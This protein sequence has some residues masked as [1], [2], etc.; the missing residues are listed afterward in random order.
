MAE[1]SLR[2]RIDGSSAGL[3]AASGQARNSLASLSNTARNTARS[4]AGLL[5]IGS[6]ALIAREVL[7]SA[8]AYTN[9]NSR[10]RLVTATQQ[11]ANVVSAQ[12]F[13]IAQQTRASLTATGE[14]YT[15]LARSTADLG[16]N[17]QQLAQITKTVNQSFVV[18]GASAESAGN[19][20]VQL[21]QGLASGALRGD[22]FN[23]VAEQAPII[24]DVLAKALG[25][26]RGE[27]REFAATGG[28]T[29]KI[30]TDSLLVGAADVQKQFDGMAVTISG[31]STQIGNAF[32]RFVGETSTASGAAS[33][34]AAVLSTIASN[35]D[36]LATAVL[37]V[38]AALLTRYVGAQVAAAAATLRTSL[39]ARAIAK[40][41]VAASV[42]SSG[43]AVA[44]R[45]LFALI[46]G[47]PVLI[48]G[49]ALG[50]GVLIN[51]LATAQER[52]ESA[53]KVAR[54]TRI[55]QNQ[56]IV[57]QN[58]E[59]RS[60]N[61][62][63]ILRD[64]AQTE[65]SLRQLE[66]RFS[67]TS[68]PVKTLRDRLSDLNEELSRS[69]AAADAAN[70]T[71]IGQRRA[72]DDLIAATTKQ[73]QGM[74]EQIA[75]TNGGQ[76]AVLKLR[77]EQFSAADATAEQKK[78]ITELL[79]QLP[80]LEARLK[81][82][83]EEQKQS[84]TETGRAAEI[85]RNFAAENA[86][87]AADLAGPQAQAFAEYAA[88]IAQANEVL[89]S[90]AIGVEAFAERQKL[91]LEQL[92]RTTAGIQS[93]VAPIDELIAQIAEEGQLIGL[94]NTER[95]VAIALRQAEQA[96]QQSGVSLTSEEAKQQLAVVEGMIRSNQAQQQAVDIA[97][98][99]AEDYQRAWQ[100]ATDSVLRSFGDFVVRG[101]NNFKSLGRQ[102]KNIAQSFLADLVAMFL[103]NKLV[104]NVSGAGAGGIG[105]LF[106]GLL[107]P[108]Q[109]SAGTSGNP[110]SGVGPLQSFQNPATGG[111]FSLGSI[112]GQNTSGSLLGGLGAAAQSAAIGSLIGGLFG[113]AGGTGGA[114]GGAVGSIFGPLGA[115][116]GSAIGGAIGSLFGKFK[117]TGSGANFTIG[118]SGATGSLFEDQK[119]GGIF[120]KKRRTITSAL[121]PETQKALD[122]LFAGISSAVQA[123]SSALAVDVPQLISGTFRREFDKKGNLTKEFSTIAG[124]VVNE[125]QEAFAQR[126]QALNIIAVV[127]KALGN[128]EASAIAQQFSGDAEKL[129]GGAQFLLAAAVDV[130][131]GFGLLGDGTLTEISALVTDVA[132][133]GEPLI[134]TYARLVTSSNLLDQALQLQG[135]SLDLGRE[136]F[137][138]FAADIVDAAGGL[139]R[140]TSLWQNYFKRFF[141]DNELA[142]QSLT[143]AQQAAQLQFGD[144]GLN[145]SDFASAEGLQ[146]FRALFEQALPTLS[147]DAV[148]QWLEAAQAIGVV[149]DA[150]DALNQTLSTAEQQ[151][152]QFA[153]DLA[154]MMQGIREQSQTAADAL[155]DFGL[156][157]LAAGLVQVSRE[158]ERAIAE[159]QRL[160]A[161]ESDLA[162]IRA[163]GQVRAELLQRQAQAD[164]ADLL[165]GV[166]QSLFELDA[167]PLEIELTRINSA[168]AETI[169]Q[170]TALGA[171][172]DQLAQIRELA[173][174]Q[175]TNAVEAEVQRMRDAFAEL[176]SAIGDARG[177]ISA[178]ILNIRRTQPGFSEA[179]FQRG[180]IT[181]LRDQLAGAADPQAQIDLIDQIRQATVARYN[182]EISDIQQTAAAQ[183]QAAQA[184]QQAIDAQRQALARLRDFADGLGLSSN[185]PLTAFQRLDVAKG[186]FDTLLGRARGGDAEAIGGLQQAAEAL[187]AE[188]RNVFGVSNT[189]VAEFDRVQAALRSVSGQAVSGASFSGF[190]RASID[191]NSRIAQLQANAIAEL[192]GLDDTLATLSVMQEAESEGTIQAL[193]DRF[194]QAENHNEKLIEHIQPI[195]DAFSQANATGE[196][197]VAQLQQQSEQL[198]AI[199]T[200][201]QNS[202]DINAAF[203]DKFLVYA[204]QQE[205]TMAAMIER[206]GRAIERSSDA[207]VRA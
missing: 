128:G 84:N 111:G 164:L 200:D 24:M 4:M 65:R 114:V 81:A 166:S 25:K 105:S 68:V 50:L 52:A 141:S 194:E 201:L 38:S 41:F 80:A 32:S 189:A 120:G 37:A 45:G 8:D 148:V 71:L 153:D 54:D 49:A 66:Q 62:D 158:T 145:A 59:V 134:E 137:V 82:T 31:A 86:K 83:K 142:A 127:D 26:S 169:A 185:S 76:A 170:A 177:S 109:A 174:R 115:G 179:G 12:V 110:F 144:I 108:G 97:Q 122:D 181:S 138:R 61:P 77:L 159:A 95:E 70:P 204:Q 3:V 119:K 152:N 196:Q 89:A 121:D 60:A 129:L 56:R 176:A 5:G 205:T 131:N 6:V 92:N 27:L 15:T 155:A 67:Q 104:L 207:K 116:I 195:F 198:A 102:L 55:D 168:M 154:Q 42:A 206:L 172:E 193:R 147:A 173:A 7:R 94:N 101:A 192:Q 132:K 150:Q 28:I 107:G 149:I 88:G 90:G 21:S 58:I 163:L 197:Q 125:S 35:F 167:S 156:A 117:T 160:G 20:I 75:A 78:Q 182:A 40:E 103:R 186:Q 143:A 34:L 96:L 29:A 199:S 19:A 171:S 99:A 113:G 135:Q 73:V 39:A 123:A 202:T 22:E 178:D 64:I 63:L 11:Q 146:Q 74:R 72:I 57:Q 106:A 2:V 184:A 85:A 190:E 14:L 48:A 140:A 47:W 118:S 36:A 100:G 1:A 10:I 46:G 124:K 162:Q 16:L 136:Q 112:F 188:N 33:G 165:A 18:S 130:K 9:L 13:G 203:L 93:Q 126:L 161:T 98:Q 133:A 23:S 151:I 87:L 51:R 139:D 69:K 30:L 157:D 191:V 180:Q 91:L 17:Q 175:S 183:D 43:F 187:L 79:A 44:G 53:A